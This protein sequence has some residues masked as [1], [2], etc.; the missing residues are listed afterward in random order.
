[1]FWN[2]FFLTYK[3]LCGEVADVRGGQSQGFYFG[4]LPV[5]GLGGDEGPQGHECAVHTAQIGHKTCRKERASK[6]KKM[7]SV[8]IVITT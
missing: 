3:Q 2:G 7:T 8:S 1:M 5:G 4:E 6:Y